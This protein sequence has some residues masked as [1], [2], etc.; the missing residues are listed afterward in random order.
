MKTAWMAVVCALVMMPNV[1]HASPPGYWEVDDA[2]D[3]LTIPMAG[4]FVVEWN[5]PVFTVAEDAPIDGEAEYD[6]GHGIIFRASAPLATGALATAH[7]VL[8]PD[9]SR[10]GGLGLSRGLAPPSP[11]S[12]SPPR[13]RWS[14]ALT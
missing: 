1:T 13:C 2:V 10:R 9:L 5:Q 7:V 14:A 3:S 4:A 12:A 8:E 6:G 11:R